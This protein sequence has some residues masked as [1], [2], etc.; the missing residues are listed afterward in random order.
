[1]TPSNADKAIARTLAAAFEHEKPPVIHYWDDNRNSSVHVLS[2]ADRP[3]DG[4]TSYGT[5]GLS[6][7]PMLVDGEEFHA[8]V[9]VL[10]ACASDIEYF[11]NV[12]STAAFNVIN[13][14]A[15]VLPGAVHAGAIAMYDENVTM[16]HLLFAPTFIWGDEPHTMYL[17]DKTVAF[18]FAVPI[19]DAELEYAEENGTEQLEDM[20]EQNE[21]DVFDIDRPSVV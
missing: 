4:V 6:N 2:A 3:T 17:R 19:S 13:S 12:M 15:S 21:I 16:K 7:H 8:R 10:G 5:V 18:L 1:M 20:F 11:G 14:G 9:E